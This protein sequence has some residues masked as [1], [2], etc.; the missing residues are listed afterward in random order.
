M[1]RFFAVEKK[2]YF[3]FM[4]VYHFIVLLIC[5]HPCFSLRHRENEREREREVGKK[6]EGEKSANLLYQQESQ[7]KSE[8]MKKK[9]ILEIVDTG[10]RPPTYYEGSRGEAL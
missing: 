2:F 4:I 3:C 1:K 7:R 10:G 6:R 5:H 8:M 9:K